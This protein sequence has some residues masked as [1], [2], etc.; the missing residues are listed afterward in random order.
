MQRYAHRMDNFGD[1]QIRRVE[2]ASLKPHY[3]LVDDAQAEIDRLKAELVRWKA[4]CAAPASIDLSYMI[5]AERE[6]YRLH[7]KEFG[8]LKAGEV[9]G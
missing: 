1:W 5:A 9:K 8:K 6:F 2:E 4:V 3:F 7:K